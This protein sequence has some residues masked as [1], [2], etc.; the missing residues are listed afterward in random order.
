MPLQKEGSK[1]KSLLES[2]DISDE[3]KPYV[4]DYKI[5]LVEIAWQSS[6]QVA[7]YRSDFK[8]VADYFVQKRKKHGRYTPSKDEI[9]HVGSVLKMMSAL[10]GDD[11]FKQIVNERRKGERKVKNMCEVL[12]RAEKKGKKEGKIELLVDLLKEKA[13]P[14]AKAVEKSGLSEKEFIKLSGMK[15]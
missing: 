14:F 7:L 4:N 12:D 2:L 15:P 13:I 3:L 5:N 1:P 9:R 8:I 11:R 6:E 10:T